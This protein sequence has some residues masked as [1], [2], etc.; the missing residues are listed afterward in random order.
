MTPTI[1]IFIGGAALLAAS[2]GAVVVCGAPRGGER[3]PFSTASTRSRMRQAIRGRMAVRRI[4]FFFPAR[5]IDAHNTV[6]RTETNRGREDGD[7][8][9]QRPPAQSVHT[10]KQQA[11]TRD[12]PNACVVGSDVGFHDVGEFSPVYLPRPGVAA[13]LLAKAACRFRGAPRTEMRT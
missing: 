1:Y 4:V 6:E 10:A 3:F 5:G 8:A 9:E 2:G 7:E 11:A 13:H 12:K